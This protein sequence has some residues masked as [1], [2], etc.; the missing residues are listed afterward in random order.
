MN[1][2]QALR[3]LYEVLDKEANQREVAEV[4]THLKN[5]RHCMAR[6]EFEKMF[7]TLVV[8]KGRNPQN[9]SVI[10]AKILTQLDAIDAS[11]ELAPSSPPFRWA[12]VALATAAAIVIC[13]MASFWIGDFYNYQTEIVPFINA[14]YAHANGETNVDYATDPLDYLDQ[15]TGIRIIPDRFP[16]DMIQSVSVDTIKGVEFGCLEMVDPRRPGVLVS[17]FITRADNYTLPEKPWGQV[18]G[19]DMLVHTCKRCSMIGEQKEDYVLLIL[20]EPC[21]KPQELAQLASAL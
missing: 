13:I 1:C 16:V 9:T 15:L 10:K 20:G 5:C 8:E 14:Y 6:Y 19:R 21:C 12:A 2:R 11:G 3:L 4:E 17:I 18:N 7:Q